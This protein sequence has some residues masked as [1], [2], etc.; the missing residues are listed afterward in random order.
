[1]PELPDVEAHR[2]AVAD[3]AGGKTV[4]RVEV[5]DAELLEGTSAQGLG[6]SLVGRVVGT[7]RRRGKWLI[8]PTADEG[9]TLL[10]HFRMTGELVWLDDGETSDEDAVAFHLEDGTLSYRSRRRLGGVTYLRAAQDP[11]E[12]VGPLGP[13]ADQLDREQLA[14][15]LGG[16]RGGLKSTLMDQRRVA[17]LGNELVDEILWR[18]YLH[19]RRPAAEL[20]DDELDELHRQ[21]RMV[22]RPSIRAGHVPSGPTWLNGQRRVEGPSCPRC[23]DQLERARVAGRTT[24][25]CPTEQPATGSRPLVPGEP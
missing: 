21:L 16:R 25:W 2:R 9:P 3:H 6:R 24:F 19:P 23:G 18:S 20:E 13:D 4:R 5:R 12:V 1:V 10:F 11:E 15:I 22:L 7:P 17:G 14:E 8:V